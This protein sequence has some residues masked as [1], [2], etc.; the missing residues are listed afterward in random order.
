MVLLALPGPSAQPQQ[1]GASL[2]FCLWLT[3]LHRHLQGTTRFN[4]KLLD[5][6]PESQRLALPLT[7]LTLDTKLPLLG[8]IFPTGYIKSQTRGY[9]QEP[10]FK[11]VKASE[12]FWPY[13][14]TDLE[15]NT[16]SRSKHPTPL[17]AAVVHTLFLFLPST[18]PACSQHSSHRLILVLNCPNTLMASC[19]SK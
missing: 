16:L 10:S 13:Y 8:F 11:W 2:P 18:L 17:I 4:C 15:F 14:T 12:S 1:C 3:S 7:S 19:H 9:P 6:I 5:L